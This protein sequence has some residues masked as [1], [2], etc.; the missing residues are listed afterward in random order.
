MEKHKRRASLHPRK[1]IPLPPTTVS[2]ADL[3]SLASFLWPMTRAAQRISSTPVHCLLWNQTRDCDRNS[4]G[5]G[6]WKIAIPFLHILLTRDVTLKE[7]P[8]SS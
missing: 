5:S 1:S 8:V 2:Q 7:V 3:E 4:V 6:V